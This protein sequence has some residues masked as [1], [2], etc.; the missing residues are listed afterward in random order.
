VRAEGVST[1]TVGLSGAISMLH[2]GSDS[3]LSGFSVHA[4]VVNLR[5]SVRITGPKYDRT[6]NDAS[7]ASERG[8]PGHQ[9]ITTKQLAPGSMQLRFTRVDNCGRISLGEYCTHF[10]HVNDCPS[11]LL[12]GN[13]IVNGCNK[14]I[15]VHGTHS[16]MVEDNVVYNVHGANVYYENGQEMN[17]TLQRNAIGCP[18]VNGC[19]CKSCVASQA[20][21]DYGEQAG[22]YTLSAHAMSMIENR[23]WCACRAEH[24]EPHC[25]THRVAVK[26]QLYERTAFD[27]LFRRGMENAHFNNQQGSGAAG[28]DRAFNN[29]CAKMMPAATI[30]ANIFHN[31][32]GQPPSRLRL[33]SCAHADVCRAFHDHAFDR[34]RSQALAGT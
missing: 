28:Q 9:G 27:T 24:S 12:Q 26:V 8:S 15:T 10:H 16:S 20:D 14:G 11:C 18:I 5:R 33:P 13:A 2:L 30:R 25:L 1:C 21:S 4:E 17:N 31:N 29:V 32:M 34:C 19:R 23:V 7:L 22:I 3:A 6:I